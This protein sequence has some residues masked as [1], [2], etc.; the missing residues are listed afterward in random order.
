MSHR[1][2][3][4]FLLFVVLLLV[5]SFPAFADVTISGT[6]TF[7]ALDGSALDDDHTV[8]G[9]FTVNGNLTVL[10]TIN[11][12]DASS[13][14]GSSACP[15]QFAVTGNLDLGPGSGVFAEN[16]ASDGNGANITF[17]VGG[18]VLIEGPSGTLAGAIVSSSK[19]NGGNPAHAGDISF[20]AGGTFTQIGGS[21]ISAAASDS[22]AGAISIISAG[23][24]SIGGQILAGPSRTISTSTLYTG[25]I[26]TGGGGH[27]VGG[28]ITIKALTSGEPGVV[29]SSTA[30]VAS[31][32]SETL[33]TTGNPVT[34]EGCGVQIN[35]LVASIA[36]DGSG[37]AVIV[38]GG[39][40][41]VINSSNLGGTGAFRGCLRSDATAKNAGAMH[42]DLYAREAITVTGPPTSSSLFS[43]TS[44][45]GT[46][47]KWNAGTIN[48]ISTSGDVTASG[49]AFQ[50]SSQVNG[51]RGGT[52]NVSAKNNVALTGTTIDASGS[53]GDGNRAGGHI[54]VRSY[55]ASVAWT[56]GVGD[57]RPV[58]SSA[59]VPAGQQ[60]TISLTYCTTLTTSG[61]SFPTNG[62]PVGTFPTTTQTCS[63]AA[64]TLPAGNT[65]PACNTA[66]VA[67]NDAYTVAEGGTL[68]VPAPGV[69]AN[70]TDAEANPLTAILVSGP[71]HASSFTLNSDGSFTYVHD[72]S[73]TTSDSF[74]YK[75]NDGS[76]DSNV[77]T[78]NI[79][80]TPVNDAP[81]ANN[82]T[83]TVAEGGT[84][85]MAAPGV[86]ANDTDPD[87]P[88]LTAVLVSG[89]AH[90][91]S[92][93]LNPDGSYVYVHDGSET[94]SDSFTYK[95]SDGSLLSN[96]ATVSI[97]ITPVNDAP[98]ANNDSYSVAEGGTLNVAAPG[99]LGNDTDPDSPTLTAI[100][101][102]GPA[103]A[104]SFTLN[105]N[106]SFTYVHDGS[107]TLS[108]SFTYKAN[109][110]SLNSNI[111]TANITITPV[112]DAPTAVNDGPY[113]VA[114]GGTLN[115][116]APGV[117]GND[118]DPDSP[119][120]TAVLVSGPSHASSFTLNANGSFT[121]VHDGSE[122]LSDSFTYKANDGSLDSNVATVSITITPVNDPPTAVN[123]SAT[124]AEGGTLN[125][126]APGV[127]GNDTDP[128]SPTLTAILVTGPAHASSF[129]LN[130]DG[131]Y[132][133]VHDGSETLSDSFTYKA[134][135]GFLDSNVATVNITITPVNDAPVA[136]DDAYSVAEGGTLSIAAPGVLGNDTDADSPTLTAVLVSSPLH[137]A[138][139][140]LNA[141]GSFTYVHDGS[142]TLTDSFTYKAND[143][144]LDSNVATVTITVTPV[145]DAPVANDDTYGVA[146]GGTL[147]VA[148]PGVLGN[149]TDVDSPTI[150]AILV[151]GPSHASSFTLNADGSF[152][153]VHDGSETT[154]DSFT[155]KANDGSLDSNVATVTI[156]ISPVNDAPTANNDAY[157]VAEGGT[158]N[159]AAPGVI[160]NDTD[161]DSP[162]LTAVLVSGP[163][164][165]SSF[166]LN[167]DGSFTY[168]HDGSETLS[169]SFT[170]KVSDGSLF[171]NVATVN[172]TVTPVNDA[173]TAVNDGPYTVA[174]GGTLN[175]AAPGVLGN[176]TDPDSPT[177][178]AV[179]VS[180]PSHASSFTLNADGSFTYVHDGSE[181]LSDSFTY[182]ASDGSLFSNVATVSITISPVNDPPTANNDAYSVDEGGTLNVAAP[183]VLGNDTDPDGPSISA[184]LVSGPAHASSFTLNADGS[185]SYVHDGSET[186]S[187]SFTYKAND[188][189]A[190]SNVATVTITVNPVDDAPVAN[191]DAYGVAEGGTLS[192][193]APGVLGNDTD[194]DSPTLT[195]VLVSSPT[196]A[197]SFTLNADGS[198]TYVHDGSETTT[199][200]F[201]YKAND[202]T[203]DSNVA[204]VT[205]TITAVNDAPVITAGG[206]LSYTENDPASVV[207]NTITVS[208]ADSASLAGATV[209]ITSNYVNGQD[210]LSF[211]TIGPI[212]GSFNGA[213]GTLTLTGTDTVANYQAALRTVKYANT[214][215]APSTAPRTVS[216]QVNDGA[217][218]NNLSNVATSTI[219]VTSVNDA[220]VLTGGATLAY[221][222][223]QAA[224]AIDTTITV[225]DIDSATLTSA[226]IQITGNYVS[227]QDVLSYTTALGITGS[228]NAG[229]GTLTLSGVAS[230]AN[231]QTAL[232]NVKYANTSDDPST[233]PRTVTFQ[234]NDGG[235]VNNLSNTISSTINITAVND[236]PTAFAFTNLPAQAGIPIT[237]PAGKLGGSDLEAGTTITIDTTPINLVNVASLTINANGSFTFTPTPGS[238]GGTAS[239][240]YRVSDNGNPPPGANSAYV[241]VSFAVAGPAIY[242]TKSAAVGTGNCTLGSE[243]TVATAVTN[244]GAS[245]NAIIFI[246]DANTQSPGAITLNSGGS[247]IGQGVIDGTFDSFFGIGT[248]SQGTLAARPSINAARPTLSATNITMNTN[249]QA[250]GFNLS[251]TSGNSLSSSGKT[252]LVVS[253]M[254]ISSTQASAASFCVNF[255]TSSGTFAFGT[256]TNTNGGGGV[257]FNA[258]T[259][260]SAVTFGNI[261]TSSGPAVTVASSGS[262][263]FTF[264]NVTSTTGAA[265]STNTTSSG[266]FTFTNVTSSTGTAVT[267]NTGT[268]AFTFAKISNNGGTKGISVNSLNGAGSFTVNG[269]GGLCDATHTTASDC[270]GGTIQNDSARGAEFI[271]SNNVTLKNMY[272]K[273][274]GTTVAGGCIGNVSAGSNATCNGAVIL[275]TVSGTTN[276]A[277]LDTVFIDGSNQMGVAAN[278]VANFNMTN[279]E[280]R[281]VG[282]V[283]GVDQSALDLQNLSGTSNL[284][285][286][287]H[288]HDND[289][290]HN[291]FITNNTGTATINF[292]NNT[293]DNVTVANPAQ[294]DGFQIQAYSSANVTATVSNGAGT[295]TFNKLFSNG[296]T[297]GAN[298]AAVVNATLQNC[299]VTLTSG[300]LFEG[301]GTS[302]MTGTIDANT[303]TNKVSTDWTGAGNGSNAITIG[304][305][306][307]SSVGT[308][309]GTVTNNSITKAH[310]GGACAGIATAA[311]GNGTTTMT[312]ISNNVQ[313][314][315]G[316]GINFVTGQA[317][318]TSNNVLTIQKNT[319]TNPDSNFNYAVDITVGTTSGDHPCVAMNLGD[320]SAAH[321]VPA[322]VNT[323]T[324]GSTGFS[325]NLANGKPSIS[326]IG[327]YAAGITGTLKLFNLSG[328]TNDLAAQNW[329]KNSNTPTADSDAFNNGVAWVSGTTCP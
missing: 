213:T 282:S 235:A 215:D 21:T 141:D 15:M 160:A 292:T 17:N 169:D 216:W 182:K 133:Y 57:V 264:S 318:G 229:S 132:T 294:S 119:T 135:D 188:G 227:G 101:V 124:V 270:T 27:T 187:D 127:L 268:G 30:I 53:T 5:A 140:T 284:I 206:T 108:D 313:H 105:A 149:D 279:S 198:F 252:G 47:T 116:A 171:S 222:E 306:S 110:G 1:P 274:N 276:G 201:T 155:Y 272:F 204:T 240:Q 85:N 66:P 278:G 51:D 234:V 120:L 172:I 112:N 151:S 230:L 199:D 41:I 246:G 273:T 81:T 176:D 261:Q 103:H 64:P 152:T 2:W 211:A 161:P 168:V 217:G 14:G 158:L 106:G 98:T 218:V 293:V 69:L 38:R 115:V 196:H 277:K 23:A 137:A 75:A 302:N 138:S 184:I 325:W 4:R 250:R 134:N 49:N 203:L 327:N 125:V 301:S 6:T 190:D 305:S 109:D 181:T 139:F 183:G 324:N 254:N 36:R 128:D 291:V 239:F 214:S 307:S 10:G 157:T 50:A 221:T 304:K 296:V 89:P 255:S 35:G 60:G 271:N 131:S 174:E 310:C 25:V 228:F 12:N 197:A 91:S 224:T 22:N 260:A 312:V 295:C 289:F 58:G 208:D 70:D 202:G 20:T 39:T 117:L 195:A 283:T 126:A 180:G 189:L 317:S 266:N 67:N 275:Q 76:S 33:P 156:N 186:T 123:D 31:Q 61:T 256:I 71:A 223:N 167:G 280:V 96:T 13:G 102:S 185:F 249:S 43:V 191:N 163:A 200:T 63:P 243:C 209:Q 232:R 80:I 288:I 45:P 143:G 104:S 281:G 153:Y 192:V 145:N 314:V 90:A 95:A 290:G 107:E 42:V 164:H 251:S 24:A 77:A 298:N 87:S 263:N 118:T 210:I 68:N 83:A 159:V 300:V 321:T 129:T 3:L 148:A 175:V 238:A 37:P 248:P 136:N 142:E 111:A 220:P 309:T 154:T 212:S 316:E 285:I 114:E 121:Y 8:N 259:S 225:S 26:M 262:T 247:I 178:T 40:S 62:S 326:P 287:S 34:L 323:I 19:L 44:N 257:S 48:V 146:E 219:N 258:T 231:Y 56:S 28:A 244:I 329:I 328:G 322:N 74:T 32:G 297:M 150:T 9:I 100:L 236:P 11:C 233:L 303:I 29:V 99:V 267:V 55:S 93:T 147:N 265:V 226:T 82:D 97:T 92:F 59:G 162:T 320:M 242:F 72:G 170:Y 54:N 166:T 113:T 299:T 179:L 319:I 269:T 245:T 46:S 84:I 122:T 79:T 52:I 194:V 86:L 7:S 18:N 237:Y 177:L 88:T 253:D 241:T 207:D 130:S 315:D 205:I 165:A 73:E 144:S 16:R 311:F 78:V 65:L 173:P 94:T 286:G 308:F 193:A